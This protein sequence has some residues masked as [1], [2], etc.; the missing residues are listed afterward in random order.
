M[1]EVR[2]LMAKLLKEK[3]HKISRVFTM[4]RMGQR[5][6]ASHGKLHHYRQ[7]KNMPNMQKISST[8]E[9]RGRKTQGRGN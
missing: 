6:T 4:E 2:R 3:F 7:Y 1:L 9:R 5:L 8:P